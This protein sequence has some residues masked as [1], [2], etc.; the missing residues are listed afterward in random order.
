MHTDWRMDLV[1]KCKNQLRIWDGEDDEIPDQIEQKADYIMWGLS[2]DVIVSFACFA[3]LSESLFQG[4]GI[5]VSYDHGSILFDHYIYGY[6]Y[7]AE[8]D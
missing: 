8:I 6:H 3:L 5:W 7:A 2:A 4:E 1:F